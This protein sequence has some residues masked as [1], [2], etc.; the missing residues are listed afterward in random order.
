[1]SRYCDISQ[2]FWFTD[3]KGRRFMCYAVPIRKEQTSFYAPWLDS[4]LPN[5]S[6]EYRDHKG[7]IRRVFNVRRHELEPVTVND[8]I[9]AALERCQAAI[10]SKV[11]QRTA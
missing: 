6:I 5:Y 11:S 7:V 2:N 9:A 3:S 1:M 4:R 10:H 8:M